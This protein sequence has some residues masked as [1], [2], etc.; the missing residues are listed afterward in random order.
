MEYDKLFRQAA[1]LM[2]NSQS[3]STSLIQRKFTLG[4]NR[5]GRI[6]DQLENLNIVGEFQ[7]A[8]PREVKVKSLEELNKIL[9]PL[10]L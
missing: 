9:K 6:I 10:N 3:G 7:G 2:V 5:S 8:K 4:Y 1:E